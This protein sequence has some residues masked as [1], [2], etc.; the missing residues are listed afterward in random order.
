MR[1]P[2]IYSLSLMLACL[3]LCILWAMSCP[4]SGSSSPGIHSAVSKAVLSSA[5]WDFQRVF[6]LTFLG[7][8]LGAGWGRRALVLFFFL[9]SKFLFPDAY[10][11]E[12]RSLK[13]SSVKHDSVEGEPVG[14]ALSVCQFCFFF[15]PFAVCCYPA[16]SGSSLQVSGQLSARADTEIPPRGGCS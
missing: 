5:P 16:A 8:Q 14:L 2:R 4:P 10:R 15:F 9:H 1:K 13:S 7:R 6:M 12:N 11:G 3:T